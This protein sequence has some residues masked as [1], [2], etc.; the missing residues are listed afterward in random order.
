MQ[1]FLCDK[2]VVLTD[3]IKETHCIHTL[4]DNTVLPLY[5]TVISMAT[6]TRNTPH[7][8]KSLFLQ[9]IK[10]LVIQPI[11]QQLY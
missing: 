11:A 2:A 5:K 9:G 7:K 8:G 4:P 1:A 10:G 6:T 3:T